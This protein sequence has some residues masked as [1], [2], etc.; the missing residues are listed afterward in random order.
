MSARVQFPLKYKFLGVM[1]LIL[2]SALCVFFFLAQKTFSEDKKLFVMDLNLTVLQAT[3]A[4]IKMQLKDRLEELQLLIPRV[5]QEPN[6]KAD[7]Y[8]GLSGKLEDEVLGVTFYRVAADGKAT[9]MS[10][11]TNQALLTTRKFPTTLLSLVDEKYPLA[12]G[13]FHQ[14]EG[15]RL[16]NRSIHLGGDKEGADAAIITFLISGTILNSE[17]KNILIAVDFLQDFLRKELGKTEMAEI[18]LMFK[19]GTLLSHP[20]EKLTVDYASVPYPHPIAERLKNKQFARESME[21]TVGGE[22]YL[23]NLSETG[24]PDVFAISQTRKREAFL[25]LHTLLQRS[26]WLAIFILSA[27][28][29]VSVFFASGLT[30][31]IKK[32]Q[33]ASE[34]IGQGELDYKLNVTSRDE[35]RSVGDSFQKMAQQLKN[36]ISESAKKAIMEEELETARLVQSTLLTLPRLNS[37]CFD[38]V[39][40]YSPATQCGG[41]YWDACQNGDILTVFIGDAT[42]HGAPAAIVTAVAKSCF[43][44]LTSIF[45]DQAL[46]PEELLGRLNRIIYNSCQGKLL[47]TMSIVQL[48]LK[49]GELRFASAGHESPLWLKAPP[50]GAK[51]D[52]GKK[53]VATLFARGE[54]LGFNPDQQYT[55]ETS[56]LTLGDVLLLYTDGVSEAH[57]EAG[58]EWGERALKKAFGQSG[59][60]PLAVIRKELINAIETHMGEKAPDDDVTFVLVNWKKEA[61]GAGTGDRGGKT[62]T[63][64]P[65]LHVAA[66]P[67]QRV[68]AEEKP[69]RP[70]RDKKIAARGKKAQA[71]FEREEQRRND[72]L[73]DGREPGESDGNDEAA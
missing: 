22:D 17:S 65:K 50:K 51:A 54:R 2:F 16:L 10:R 56:Q 23:C 69:E 18:F 40:H 30:A 8:Q 46:P 26:S 72:Y 37:D 29:M 19:N 21:L 44:T 13:S 68:P 58:E 43:A 57:N 41:D 71:S 32:L 45:Q 5:Y 73:F 47:M 63:G 60:R 11:Y 38:L 12:L 25:A 34:R 36:L 4:E 1:L 20:S 67:A 35:I 61:S 59:P 70:R 48:N 3:T 52:G 55:C 39:S 7:I 49:S 15:V 62:K 64:P 42:G 24:F 14:T 9:Q 28:A 27:A 33:E 6:A 31:N 53:K 66:A